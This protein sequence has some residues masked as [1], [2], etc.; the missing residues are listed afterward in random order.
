MA[1]Q[2][3]DADYMR[4]NHV[5]PSLECAKLCTY[6]HNVRQIAVLVDKI[7][8]NGFSQTYIQKN[9][10]DGIYPQDWFTHNYECGGRVFAPSKYSQLPPFIEKTIP[11]MHLYDK[12]INKYGPTKLDKQ[13]IRRLLNCAHVRLAPDSKN[14]KSVKQLENIMSIKP[15]TGIIFHDYDLGAIPNAPQILYDISQTREYKIKGGIHEYPIGNKFPIQLYNVDEFEKWLKVNVLREYLYIQYNGIMSDDFVHDLCTQNKKMALQLN[16]NVTYDCSNETDFLD[17]KIPRLINQTT[18]FKAHK[19]RME[20]FIDETII[21]TKELQ[22]FMKILS[23]WARFKFNDPYASDTLYHLCAT[24]RKYEKL[25]Y[26][27]YAFKTIELSLQE[28]R[29]AFQYIRERN[30]DIFKMLYE[31]NA[32]PIRKMYGGN[33]D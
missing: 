17:N 7:D 26:Y 25:R 27:S 1:I 5:I 11:D 13:R 16:Y 18:L 28:M 4:Y 30:Y 20:Y 6:Y 21:V 33:N 24:C 8:P 14:P 22:D 10:D 29:N 32:L 31:I 3:Y 12:Y 9:Y 15:Y 19:I 2:I 23:A